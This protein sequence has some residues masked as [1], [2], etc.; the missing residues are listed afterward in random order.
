MKTVGKTL[1]VLVLLA[2]IGGLGYLLVEPREAPGEQSERPAP[3]AQATKA[4]I[5]KQVTGPGEVKAASVDKLK[6]PRWRYL[7]AFVA[8]LNER[9]PAGTPL[10]EYTSGTPLVAPYDLVVLSKSLPKEKEELTD[11]HFV[12]VARVD[13]MHVEFDAHENDIATL[14][15]GQSVEVA[16]GAREG[17]KIAGTVVSINQ[18]GTYGAT[19]SKYKVTVEIPNG[20]ELLIG[21]SANVSINVAEAVDVITVPVS[22]IVA[23]KDGSSTVLVQRSNGAAEPVSVETGLS[24]G[25]TV[26][27]K[28]GLA[29]GDTVVLNET[30]G[31]DADAATG[32]TDGAVALPGMSWGAL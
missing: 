3:V 2:A 11:E 20:G 32:M 30:N 19:G 24:D 8:P 26:E 28:S 14:A 25:K 7:K 31:G 1:V 27:V 29:E 13:A 15:K 22:A 16:I 21:M 17:E 18:V 9:I 23:G 5:T 4:T 10:V 6:N 12:E